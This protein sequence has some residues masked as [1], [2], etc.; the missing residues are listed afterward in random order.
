MPKGNCGTVLGGG[1]KAPDVSETYPRQPTDRLLSR[2]FAAATRMSVVLPEVPGAVTV[3]VMVW[4]IES[5]VPVPGTGLGETLT[6]VQ[7]PFELEADRVNDAA[8]ALESE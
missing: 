8:R 6:T 5:E 2:L 3:T 1:E 4:L 7:A